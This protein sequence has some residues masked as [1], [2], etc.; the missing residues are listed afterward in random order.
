MSGTVEYQLKNIRHQNRQVDMRLE[1]KKP[2]HIYFDD[3]GNVVPNFDDA[4][5]VRVFFLLIF[6][7]FI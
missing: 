1:S 3:D 6:V 5:E 2:Q 4:G 7:Y